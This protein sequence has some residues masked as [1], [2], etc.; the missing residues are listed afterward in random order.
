MKESRATEIEDRLINLAKSG[1]LR[2]KVTEERLKEL[3]VLENNNNNTQKGEGG[4]KIV[5]RRR[6]GEDE[7]EDLMDF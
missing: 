2:A 7:D 5:V 6:K 1:Q 3:L 4:G